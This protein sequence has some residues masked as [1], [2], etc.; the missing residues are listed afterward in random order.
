MGGFGLVAWVERGNSLIK[1]GPN[2]VEG[3]RLYNPRSYTSEP[4]RRVRDH[5]QGRCNYL[6][7]RP[8]LTLP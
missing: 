3:R 6:K 7:R 4:F 5:I 2:P 8:N 1:A